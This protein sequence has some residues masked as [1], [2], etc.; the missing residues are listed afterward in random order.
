MRDVLAIC[1]P[2]TEVR[3]LE[4]PLS[5]RSVH[6]ES[7]HHKPHHV[8]PREAASLV[9]TGVYS[10][11]DQSYKRI[12]RNFVPE[13]RTRGL[14]CRVGPILAI[15]VAN[16]FEWAVVMLANTYNPPRRIHCGA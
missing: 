12:R 2:A 13:I 1:S 16:K 8:T 4:T 7:T 5:R 11:T 9:S 10:W 3:R 15:A 14:S 6:V